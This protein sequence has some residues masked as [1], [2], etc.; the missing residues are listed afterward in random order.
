MLS[1]HSNCLLLDAPISNH[2]Q[3]LDYE[4]GSHCVEP[5]LVWVSNSD[6]ERWAWCVW[7]EIWS[8]SVRSNLLLIIWSGC[9][10][11][12]AVGKDLVRKGWALHEGSSGRYGFGSICSSWVWKM[13]KCFI[14]YGSVARTFTFPSVM[15]RNSTGEGGINSP[16]ICFL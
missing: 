4:P 15:Q 13:C 3:D 11:L 2:L 16:C 10:L 8:V 12:W 7:A 5:A 9:G 14:N 1:A 6:L